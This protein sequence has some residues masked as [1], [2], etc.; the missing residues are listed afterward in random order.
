[1]SRQEYKVLA[2]FWKTRMT[3]QAAQNAYQ[4]IYFSPFLVI[5]GRVASRQ[6]FTSLPMEVSTCVS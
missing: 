6:H 1:M 3:G 4:G 2:G 5:V